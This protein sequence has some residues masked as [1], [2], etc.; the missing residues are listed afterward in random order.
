MKK[1]FSLVRIRWYRLTFDVAGIVGQSP[2]KID[3]RVNPIDFRSSL[4]VGAAEPQRLQIAFE[5]D[6]YP[7]T[8]QFLICD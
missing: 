7:N 1:Y 8:R 6:A 5:A 3:V 2:T 4:G